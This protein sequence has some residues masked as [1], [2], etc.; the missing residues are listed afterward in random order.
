MAQDFEITDYLPPAGGC[1][2]TDKNFARRMKDTFHYGYRNFRETIGLKWGR[3]F[4]YSKDFKFILGRDSEENESLKTFAHS[5]DFIFELENKKG[6]TLI[7]KGYDPDEKVLRVAAGL[8]QK[9]SSYKDNP[10][11][12][13]E[14][15][16]A[17]DKTQIYRVR[18]F[19]LPDNTVEKMKI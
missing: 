2:L 12:E 5:D 13:V 14:Y 6:P 18:A 7:L 1:L 15:W 17:R 3:H 10:E 11:M 8:V 19:L 9:F 4:R 16:P